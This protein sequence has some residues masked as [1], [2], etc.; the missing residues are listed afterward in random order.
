MTPAV[1]YEG[2]LARGGTKFDSS[3]DRGEPLQ[4]VIGEGQVRELLT[5][6]WSGQGSYLRLLDKDL[7]GP[8]TR[9]KRRDQVRLELRPR[10][11]A[12]VRHRPGPDQR[13]TTYWSEST[14]SS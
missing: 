13:V 7:L 9:V 8:V 4:F 12:R 6:Y 1:H 5:T 14:L 2:T 10:R 11:A 3:Y